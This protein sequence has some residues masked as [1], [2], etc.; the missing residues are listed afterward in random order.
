ML[1]RRHFLSAAAG[2]A[3]LT[4]AGRGFGQAAGPALVWSPISADI[5]LLSGAG[6]NIVVT[7]GNN[8]LLLIDGGAGAYSSQVLDALQ[9]HL[10]TRQIETLINTHWHPEQ[11]GLNAWAG[12]A[13]IPIIAHENTRLWLSTRIKLRWQDKT[14]P[15]APPE[16]RPSQTFYDDY[17]LKLEN[18]LLVCSH[19]VQAH[20]DGDIC[21]KFTRDN[22][23]VAGGVLSSDRWPVI[24]WSTA[25]WI[26]GMVQGLQSLLDKSDA[27]TLIVPATGAPVTRE[28]LMAQHAMYVDIMGQLKIMMEKGYGVADVLAEN[29]SAGY[30]PDW[31]SPDLFLALAF[32]SF[33]GHVREFDVV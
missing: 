33:W 31:G 1:H 4:L 7:R 14:Y 26:G 17:T 29:P 21:V 22:V 2:A 13:G 18:E 5:S 3:G 6:E 28:E 15:P 19:L 27:D 24:D 12:K 20:T 11:T 25:G 16:A 32:K 9:K 8:A 23:L 10:G 30:K